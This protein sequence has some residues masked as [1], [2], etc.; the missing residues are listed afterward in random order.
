MSDEARSQGEQMQRRE[1]I[2]LF[3]GA[4]ATLPLAA[5]AQR[6]ER[7]RSIGVLMAFDEDD[8]RAKVWLSRFTQGILELGWNVGHNVQ[9]D[10]RW[11][12]D[13]VDRMRMFAKTKK[14]GKLSPLS[15]FIFLTLRG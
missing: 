2:A 1:F 4:A 15:S 12:G 14:I 9:L 7:I 8:I 3:G 11:A 5:R 13:H 6:P 10:V